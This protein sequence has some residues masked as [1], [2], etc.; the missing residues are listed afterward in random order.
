MKPLLHFDYIFCAAD[1]I[2]DA[3]DCSE[4]HKIYVLVIPSGLSA[5]PCCG[6]HCEI[7]TTTLDVFCSPLPICGGINGYSYI[8][9]YIYS[10]R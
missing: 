3:E 7:A 9:V 1:V 5:L 10:P 6:W 4:W 2:P 8:Y